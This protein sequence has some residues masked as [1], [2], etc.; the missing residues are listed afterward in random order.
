MIRLFRKS[1]HAE[2]AERLYRSALSQARQPAFYKDWKVEDTVQGRFEMV[3]LHA[4][5]LLRRLKADHD[6]TGGLS[7][8]FFD[9]MVV[10]L[11]RNLR[12]LGVGDMGV[13]KRMKVM[14][15][16][17]YGRIAAY[18]AGLAGDEA[19]LREAVARNV[20]AGQDDT[21]DAAAFLAAYLLR[22]EAHLAGRPLTSVIDN[23]DWD[24]GAG[25]QS[26]ESVS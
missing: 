21:E 15:S 9:L 11:D 19:T 8:A 16:A 13:G 6:R 14:V 18:D 1:G 26:A 10:D 5:L 2:A 12:E 22:Q 4:Y 24:D 23:P 20:Y 25:L 17:F 7:Q 3:A